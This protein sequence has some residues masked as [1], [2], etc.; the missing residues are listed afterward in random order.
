MAST[1]S[2]SRYQ[3]RH[4]LNTGGLSSGLFMRTIV[5]G[6]VAVGYLV[7]AL[8]LALVVAAFLGL[9]SETMLANSL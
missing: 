3:L 7:L 2:T 1:P 5:L 9:P 6:V 4:D 8:T